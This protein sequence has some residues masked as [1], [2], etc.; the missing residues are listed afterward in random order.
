MLVFIQSTGMIDGYLLCKVVGL[1]GGVLGPVSLVGYFICILHLHSS[2]I[3]LFCTKF[4]FTNFYLA[5]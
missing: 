3:N 4:S 1:G 5:A 2:Y